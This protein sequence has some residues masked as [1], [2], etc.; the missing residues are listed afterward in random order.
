MTKHVAQ[1]GKG[2]LD[3]LVEYWRERPLGWTR[4]RYLGKIE[5][6]SI[7]WTYL[8]LYRDR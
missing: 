7:A 5:W 6:D 8:N 2:G 4:R 1:M 3:I